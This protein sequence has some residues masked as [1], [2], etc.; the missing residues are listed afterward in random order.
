M[1]YILMRRLLLASFV[2]SLLLQIF[3]Y[4]LCNETRKKYALLYPLIL[5]ILALWSVMSL[6]N[7]TLPYPDIVKQAGF[8][9]IPDS[10][11]GLLFIGS[12]FVGSIIGSAIWKFLD[13]WSRK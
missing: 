9:G 6:I 5:V 4:K 2:M 1:G 8:F 12:A 13:L 7:P 10:A 11:Y 3:L